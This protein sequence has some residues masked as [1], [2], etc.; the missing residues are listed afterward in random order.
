VGGAGGEGARVKQIMCA[1]AAV[2]P[3][4]LITGG[5][6][7]QRVLELVQLSPPAGAALVQYGAGA[8]EVAAV[9]R[10]T[11]HVIVTYHGD[12][13]R[14]VTVN[15]ESA[16]L[17][18]EHW[19]RETRRKED[20]AILKN[21]TRAA[22]DLS[23][24]SEAHTSSGDDDEPIAPTECEMEVEP[25]QPRRA[26][27][28][29][30]K[31]VRERFAAAIQ[32]FEITATDEKMGLVLLADSKEGEQDREEPELFLTMRLTRDNFEGSWEPRED[33]NG[34]V[35]S[36]YTEGGVPNAYTL[37]EEDSEYVVY[38]VWGIEE[39]ALHSYVYT[40]DAD[41]GV[42]HALLYGA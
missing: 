25:E 21:T 15:I 3:Q 36:A 29:Y 37:I 40:D 42:L 9:S 17:I 8:G 20:E 7:S 5:A 34:V 4:A 10:C 30:V 23:L 38:A 26:R 2:S 41:F 32:Y 13:G 39:I 12:D 35:C 24:T 18:E 28:P 14:V 33:V 6:D 1:T 19:E 11:D 16:V 22:R 31:I 27:S